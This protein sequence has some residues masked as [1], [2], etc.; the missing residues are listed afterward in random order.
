MTR[1]TAR[2]GSTISASLGRARDQLADPRF[3]LARTHHADPESK[4]AQR[5]TKITFDV[6]QFPLQKLAARQQ[7]PLLLSHLRLHMHWLEQADPH[8]LGNPARIVA[9]AFVDL[10]RL[11]KRHHLPGLDADYGQPGCR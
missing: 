3:E 8:H 1:R 4:I 7:H 10:L 5:S 9:I 11:Q 6:E 2:S